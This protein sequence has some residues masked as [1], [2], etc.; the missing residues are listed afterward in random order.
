MTI[1]PQAVK[2]IHTTHYEGVLYDLQDEETHN[3]MITMVLF[4]M[5]VET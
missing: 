3:Y 4:I 2:N 5:V 1:L